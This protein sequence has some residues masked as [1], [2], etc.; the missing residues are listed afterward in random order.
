MRPVQPET[1]TDRDWWAGFSGRT[2]ALNFGAEPRV[3][4]FL[5][6]LRFKVCVLQLEVLED[7]TQKLHVHFCI[8]DCLAWTSNTHDLN[9]IGFKHDNIFIRI[10]SHFGSSV[11][12]L[13]TAVVVLATIA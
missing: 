4:F 7:T 6:S 3:D 9:Q 11:E 5:G 10:R 1:N 2:F 12:V 13:P 8:F